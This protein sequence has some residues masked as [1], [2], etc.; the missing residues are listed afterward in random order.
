[1]KDQNSLKQ[2]TLKKSA[3]HMNYGERENKCVLKENKIKEKKQKVEETTIGKS[4]LIF[5]SI[6]IIFMSYLTLIAFDLSAFLT[7]MNKTLF[8]Y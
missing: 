2:N 3:F 6:H 5:K 4:A 1:M 7:E 8:I